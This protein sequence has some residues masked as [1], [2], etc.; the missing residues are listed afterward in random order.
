MPKSSSRARLSG[1]RLLYTYTSM[2]RALADLGPLTALH[3]IFMLDRAI[4]VSGDVGGLWLDKIHALIE[5][6]Q[7]FYLPVY[8]FQCEE[9]ITSTQP[10]SPHHM[11]LLPSSTSV[12]PCLSI[13]PSVVAF[14]KN[15]S[16][17][18]FIL[19]GY[20]R[21]WPAMQE[22]PW[23]SYDYLRSISGPGRM[24]PVELGRDYRT[25]DWAQKLMS[26]DHFLSSLEHQQ[27]LSHDS[28]PLYLAQ[29]N[30]FIQ[31][32]R[33]RDDILLPDYIYAFLPSHNYSGYKSP[34]TEDGVL[35][36]AWVGPMGTVSPA[37]TD[38]YH[39][40]YAQIVGR[41]TVWLAP[42]T[43]SSSMYPLD[44]A[45]KNTSMVDVF[46]SSA[47]ETDYPEFVKNAVPQA[48]SYTLDPG[49]LLFFPAGWWHAM[50]A[51]ETSISVSMWF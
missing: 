39:N 34:E 51:E 9:L 36:N 3:S 41:K 24:V 13:F 38:P 27:L 2:L 23:A 14:Q 49:D 35:L 16:R 15:L 25:D 44:A 20:A 10:Q 6:I 22:H 45:L 47:T 19:R 5:H 31:F 21:K 33:L 17:S 40:F 37:H 26:W 46:S 48:F 8:A 28:D 43:T 42:P 29:H 11:S 50:K 32:P 30:L 1:W 4:I 12:V 7:S 18:P